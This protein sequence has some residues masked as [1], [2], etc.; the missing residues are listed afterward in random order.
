M[1]NNNKQ[2]KAQGRTTGENSKGGADRSEREQGQCA[3]P[4]VTAVRK[5]DQQLRRANSPPRF[6]QPR[7]GAVMEVRDAEK[8]TKAECRTCGLKGVQGLS[9]LWSLEKG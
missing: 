5:S 3:G 9:C 1:D 4:E 6:L 2:V 7:P 8:E